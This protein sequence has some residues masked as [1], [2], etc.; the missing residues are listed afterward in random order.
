MNSKLILRLVGNSIKKNK[1]IRI[2]FFMV[3]IFT[4]MVFYIITSLGYSTYLIQDGE[5]L[6]YGASHIVVI[7]RIGSGIIAIMSF[8][9][10]LYA[11]VFIMRDRRR[12]IGLY[13]IL[14]LAKK[15]IVTM[16]A[17]ETI[18]NLAVCLGGGL[19]LGTFLNKLMLLTLYKLVGKE[20]VMGFLFSAHALHMTMMLGIG[21]YGVCFIYNICSV[22]LSKPV[23]LL[24]SDKVGEKEPK[25]KMVSLIVG[26]AATAAGYYMALTCK[27][28]I[29]SIRILFIAIVL[30]VSGTYALFRTGTIA[31]LKGIKNNKR[32]YYQ[33][34]NFIGV[35]N[36]MYRMKHNAA[37]LASICVLSSGVILL[38]SCVASLVA[39]GNQNIE[40][41]CPKDVMVRYVSSDD[42]VERRV[43]SIVKGYEDIAVE[44]LKTIPFWGT[45]WKHSDD[46]EPGV[47]GYMNEYDI[48]DYANW[49]LA[50]I[51]TEEMYNQN[52]KES[53]HVQEGEVYIYDSDHKKFDQLTVGEQ[54][55]R[56][57]GNL[58]LNAIRSVTDTTM[59]LFDQLYVLVP[60]EAAA[61]QILSADPGWS[62]E[63]GKER[64]YITSFDVNERL[65][66]AQIKNITN[67][68]RVLGEEDTVNVLFKQEEY[69][70]FKSL[71]GGV[72][73]V[74]VFLVIIF[75]MA[76][77][78]IIYY[79]QMS[80]GFED[81]HRYQILKKVGLTETEVRSSINRQVMTMFFLPLVM[82]AI[83]IIVASHIIRLFLQLIVYVEPWTFRLAIAGSI[84][85]F[86][87][88]YCLVYRVT[89]GEYYKIVN[90]AEHQA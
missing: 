57:K 13:G 72:L 65:T 25:V 24:H 79:K 59:M 6:F 76:T 46:M 37:G 78:L 55:Y 50:Y 89:S 47:Y 3:G 40:M 12:E 82:A 84:A 39:L 80:E 67:T 54:T 19:L 63:T 41:T 4:M 30:V 75:L 33:T 71:Y 44:N 18:M 51:V 1:S 31:I 58:D 45:T 34:R 62:R 14:G 77:V 88:I 53:L 90:A 29:D 22:R 85:F 74:G 5:E 27:N 70:F 11:N 81:H 16:L 73:F 35:A 61:E 86:V 10:I 42:S 52:A 23:E 83:H 21:V 20:P 9:L 15:S 26:L 36:L 49:C 32:T 48:Y 66:D 17:Y 2:P 64:M 69:D 8:I 38:I 43:D 87:V 56:V 7:L 28:T 68:M 60:D